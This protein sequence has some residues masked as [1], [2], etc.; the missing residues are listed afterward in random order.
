MFLGI[1]AVW[2]LCGS[3][4]EPLSSKM[5]VYLGNSY[6]ELL[7][8]GIE[9]IPTL[10]KTYVLHNEAVGTADDSKYLSH[11]HMYTA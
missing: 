4:I 9:L 5:G 11:L 3:G 6:F 1:V 2:R 10:L 7:S 8:L